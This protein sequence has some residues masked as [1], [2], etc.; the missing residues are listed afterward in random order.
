MAR[1]ISLVNQKGGVGK[2][3]TAINLAAY[4]AK[5]G[6]FVLLLDL[7]PQSNATSGI[8]LKTDR[9][10]GFYQVLADQIHLK[11]AIKRTAISGFDILPSSSQLA[12]ARVELINMQERE[13]K[14]REILAD[15][16]NLYDYVIV[17]CAPSLDILTVNGLVASDSVM[18]PIQSE[19]YALEGLGQLLQ[20]VELIKNNLQ[21]NLEILG[22]VITMFD[23]RNNLC[24]GVA[25]EV[26]RY[27][28]G[29]VFSSIIPRCVDLAEA[30]SFR[31]TIVEFNEH[32]KGAKAYRQLAQEIIDL[33]KENFS[34]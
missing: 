29:R 18:I 28:P 13:F 7:D 22:A 15:I 24:R 20:T 26:Q 19:Y 14:L 11:D 8:G 16:R 2:T 17:D 32:S 21:P 10:D 9:D 12:G 31:Q 34:I 6:K 27:F 1:I 25:K 5:L 3:T 4:L 33:E 23:K 30:P